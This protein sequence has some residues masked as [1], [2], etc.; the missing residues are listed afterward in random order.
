MKAAIYCRVDQGGDTEMQREALESQRIRLEE[1][2]KSHGVSIV[3]CY[4]DAGYSGHDMSRPGLAQLLKDGKAGRFQAVLVVSRTRLFRG[5]IWDEPK[6]PFQLVSTNHLE[7]TYHETR[8][9]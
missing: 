2:A 9:R 7:R 4:Q 1:Y 3:D 5:S 6:W 8:N